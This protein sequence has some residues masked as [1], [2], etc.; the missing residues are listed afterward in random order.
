MAAS[1]KTTNRMPTTNRLDALRLQLVATEMSLRVGTR[2]RQ[3][4]EE[5][6]IRTQ[7]ELADLIPSPSV[8]N[9]TV[10]KWEKGVNEPGP[11]YKAMLAEALGVDVAYFIAEEPKG[12]TPSPFPSNGI[13]DRLDS[14]EGLI[15]QV[16]PEE[17]ERLTAPAGDFETRLDVIEGEIRDLRAEHAREAVEVREILAEIRAAIVEESRARDEAQEATRSLLAAVGA[18]NRALR[19]GPQ[20]TAAAPERRAK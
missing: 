2:I 15:R 9:Q 12:P 16:T 1:V 14:I 7:R 13:T 10:N 11:K 4:R 3:R 5:L 8:T 19:A 17:I 20:R 6:G 18:A